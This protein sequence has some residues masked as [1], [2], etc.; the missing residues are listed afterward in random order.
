YQISSLHKSAAP[1]G[2]RYHIDPKPR[3]TC[4]GRKLPRTRTG[5]AL[6]FTHKSIFRFETLLSAIFYQ[7]ERLELQQPS[8][9]AL[10]KSKDNIAV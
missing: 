8:G 5:L 9:S 1:A 10:G 3:P 2:T 6:P 4:L 7:P